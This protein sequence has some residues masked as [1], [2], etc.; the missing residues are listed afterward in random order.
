[1]FII[2][3]KLDHAT[4]VWWESSL[5]DEKCSQS[6][7]YVGLFKKSFLNDSIWKNTSKEENSYV[8]S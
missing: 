6:S 8:K 2:K 7:G 3:N 5:T 4:R 1:M